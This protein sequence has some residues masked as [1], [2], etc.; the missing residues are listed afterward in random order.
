MCN[1]GTMFYQGC[2]NTPGKSSRICAEHEDLACKFKDDS[3]KMTGEAKEMLPDVCSNNADILPVKIL[4][5]KQTRS[6]KFYEVNFR[7]KIIN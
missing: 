6:G 7:Q 4:N 3:D 2:Q 1:R 5:D